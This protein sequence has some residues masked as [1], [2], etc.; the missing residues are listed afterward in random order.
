MQKPCVCDGFWENQKLF[1]LQRF[2]VQIGSIGSKTMC[3]SDGSR[4]RFAKRFPPLPLTKKFLAQQFPQPCVFVVI[5]AEDLRK[6][7]LSESFGSA[8]EKHFSRRE[9]AKNPKVLI[10]R[11]G[12]TSSSRQSLLGTPIP[13]SWTLLTRFSEACWAIP[14]DS[15]ET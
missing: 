7:L 2:P 14:G 3:F 13:D 4:C 1:V 9:R 15:C 8:V 12:W 5:L 10:L 6:L 11:I